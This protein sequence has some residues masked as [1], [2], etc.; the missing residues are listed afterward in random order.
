M[1]GIS[2]KTPEEGY[3][4]EVW[5][6]KIGYIAN[7]RYKNLSVE[8]PAS[9]WYPEYLHS[10]SNG[11]VFSL[12]L[13]ELA[14]PI[15]FIQEDETIIGYEAPFKSSAK[16]WAK[17]TIGR[18]G[19]FL[20]KNGNT[21]NVLAPEKGARPHLIVKRSVKIADTTNNFEQQMLVHDRLLCYDYTGKSSS[22]VVYNVN[23]GASLHT[24]IRTV[25]GI[26]ENIEYMYPD[27][28][29]PVYIITAHHILKF[30]TLLNFVRS[31]SVDSLLE[32][33]MQGIKLNTF[34]E[35]KF[36]GNCMGSLT[37]GA[38]V[39]YKF[40]NVF[41]KIESPLTD[42]KY[43]GGLNDSIC[44]WWNSSTSEMAT[45]RRRKI[46]IVPVA[47]IIG[48]IYAAVQYKNDTFIL[49]GGKPCFYVIGSNTV[50]PS[51][52]YLAWSAY[53]CIPDKD[54]NIYS[55]SAHGFSSV[56]LNT[57]DSIHYYDKDRYEQM[58]YDSLRQMY[59]VYNYNSLYIHSVNGGKKLDEKEIGTLGISKIEKI[60]IDNRFGNIFFKGYDNATMYN[61]ER[62]SY[63]S[64]FPGINMKN[65]T[66]YVYNG[67]LI[68]AGRFGVLFSKIIGRDSISA[69]IYCR[70]IK[71]LNYRNVYDC[72]IAWGSLL[73]NTDKGMYEV[74]IPNDTAVLNTLSN[75]SK[76]YQLVV[77]YA[78][79]V[80]SI[81]N[82]DTL[83]MNQKEKTLQFDIINP[84]GNG[85]VK[86]LCS[87]D[88]NNWQELNANEFSV[89]A[90][91]QPDHYYP[92][93]LIA[94]DNTWRSGKI[95]VLFYV[96]PYWWQTRRA[97]LLLFIAVTVSVLLL[98]AI[99]ILVT[100]R[101]VLNV[102]R[103]RHMR[104]ELELKAVYAQINPHFIF[105]SL[106]SALL[107]VRKK[108]MDEAYEHILQ[109]SRL[110]RSY[111]KSSRN[112]FI[113]IGDEINN[114]RDYLELQKTR[115]TNK[116]EFTITVAD[117]IP[118]S[119]MIPSLLLQPFVENALHHGL[120]PKSGPG[121]LNITFNT[122]IDKNEIICSID[123]N[124][125]GRRQAMEARKSSANKDES[126]GDLLIT[127][128]V[129]IFNKY[130]HMNI[131]IKYIDKEYP[132][133]GTTV[134]IH[135]KNP[136]YD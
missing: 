77:N 95:T 56:G 87:V 123:D 93:T 136:R 108:R 98:F 5:P 72:Q 42:F 89:P 109:F 119:V 45:V 75:D 10:Y 76:Q 96:H 39:N 125:I 25:F 74:A 127:D 117:T 46:T 35:D 22:F 133:T 85:K 68:A 69:P 62:Q 34:F 120:L 129:R 107:L 103:R 124:G 7:D 113:S 83:V 88:G 24:D 8:A 126:Y 12:N 28:K 100:R 18:K 21:I 40:G 31:F 15:L 55:A 53:S 101:I 30:D 50:I 70:N 16:K 11:V 81:S 90:S 19:E 26:S 115:F 36:W 6:E 106:N 54:G 58:V 112:R 23:N 32:R 110:L 61:Y 97:Q 132:L 121:Q 80:R 86:Y 128:L 73:L 17:I 66:L 43:I 82:G 27:P 63:I 60:A 104:M 122:G 135:I 47:G 37:K 64:L 9:R 38:W 3:G 67:Y 59:W 14:S 118:Q 4:W 20:L 130:E 49:S 78:D 102:T 99:S 94:S 2:A 92:L 13:R 91:C 105:N 41:K 71:D 57:P 111:I 131:A 84:Y 1:C 29:G 48:N 114:L 52:N 51:R 116:F 44:F 79:S 134:M 65:A 33:D